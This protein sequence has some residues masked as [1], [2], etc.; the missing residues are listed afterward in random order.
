MMDG[1]LCFF[2]FFFLSRNLESGQV[3]DVLC[4]VGCAARRWIYFVT[5]DKKPR[6]DAHH[7]QHPSVR[8]SVRL[9]LRPSRPLRSR[10]ALIF[11]DRLQPPGQ[12][13]GYAQGGVPQQVNF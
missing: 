9:S 12:Q 5:R 10:A 3:W 11:P 6:L 7:F 2:C 13:A 4:L 8:P 1:L